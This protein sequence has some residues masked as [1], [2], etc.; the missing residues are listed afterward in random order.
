MARILLTGFYGRGNAGDEAILQ[1]LHEALRPHHEVGIAVHPADTHPDFRRWYPYDQSTLV[2]ETAIGRL[3]DY[4]PD[5]L[6]IGGGGLSPGFGAHL[7]LTMRLLGRPTVLAGTDNL[8]LCMRGGDPAALRDYMRGFR[9]IGLRYEA[10]LEATRALG[11]EASFGADWAMALPMA[12]AEPPVTGRPCAVTVRAWDP[13]LHDQEFRY[14]VHALFR[15]LRRQGHAPFLLPVSPEDEALARALQP[16]V[17]A[18]VA[19]LWWNPR[20][21]KGLMA[22]CELVVSVGRLHPL[23]FAAPLG[24]AVCHVAAPIADA[25]RRHPLKIAQTC[26]ELRLPDLDGVAAFLAALRAGA[27][28][29][30]DPAR[31]QAAAERCQAM[32]RAVLDAL[33]VPAP[34]A[35]LPA[36]APPQGPQAAG[37][38]ALAGIA[39]MPAP[40]PA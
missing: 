13:H 3:L 35:A 11:V 32:A 21:I 29:P 28:G 16:V 22:R 27:I 1:C 14:Q 4:D 37:R 34:P 31:V 39:A 24:I 9:Y 36:G 2:D 20:A 38:D 18:P 30:A 33:E 6:V 8:D 15:G 25:S 23:I 17:D 10:G 5:A 12:P 19:C 7:A 40:M 26:R